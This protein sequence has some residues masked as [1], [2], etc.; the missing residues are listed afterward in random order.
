[1]G[2][3]VF[4]SVTSRS[5][6][7]DDCMLLAQVRRAYF[8]KK[9]R[10]SGR[11]HTETFGADDSAK[12]RMTRHDLKWEMT[13]SGH[14]LQRA[15]S[16]A[17]GGYA[18]LTWD[19]AGDLREKADFSREHRWLRSSFYRGNPKRPELQL[20]PGT[21]ETLTGLRYDSHA[22]RY[23]RSK[24]FAYPMEG[25]DSERIWMDNET[26]TPDIE[27]DTSDG[28]FYYC[29]EAELQARRAA[30]KRRDSAEA[31]DEPGWNSTQ[32]APIQFQFIRNEHVLDEA[33]APQPSLEL[34]SE[35]GP[36]LPEM[37]A[38]TPPAG[39]EDCIIDTQVPAE[40][41]VI[42]EDVAPVPVVFQPQK[43]PEQTELDPQPAALP[44]VMQ[45]AKRIV[46]SGAESYL[47]FGQLKDGR[48]QGEG[49][50]QMQSG[51]TA[52]EGG[53]SGDKREGF[54]TYYYKSGRLCYAGNW[55]QNQRSGLGVSFSARDG[56][57]F[58]GNWEDNTP[59]GRGAAFNSDGTLSY[60]GM[61][62]DG[63]RDGS[64]TEYFGGKVL[65][66]GQWRRD[67]Y[68]GQ[69]CLYL[70][71]GGTLTGTFH[72]GFAE[73]TCEECSAS[74]ETVRTGVWQHGRFVSG[75]CYRDGKPAD[76]VVKGDGA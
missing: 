70:S 28:M 31:E 39:L 58:V 23:Q 73:G 34:E 46:V 52:Y 15:V 5:L 57:L 1:M 74:G 37:E 4:Y 3:R 62:L 49:R 22:G 11:V 71:G 43:A 13:G 29:T 38:Y 40:P 54:G 6:R 10:Q 76:I 59:T 55:Q 8:E 32:G 2:D 16:A 61:W 50:T 36:L 56:S 41:A 7:E 42:E 14:V 75:V 35:D 51:H 30:A 72:G 67:C 18:V 27:A 9:P 68:N 65:Y 21:D 44:D 20:Q 24:L 26:G 19:E 53:F 17:G 25:T 69:G 33:T 47:Y 60:Y 45:P 63:L 64:G 66:E 12:Y 48:R